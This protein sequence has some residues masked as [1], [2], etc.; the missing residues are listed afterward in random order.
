MEPMS[1]IGTTAIVITAPAN[2]TIVI[3][4]SG[5]PNDKTFSI[6]FNGAGETPLHH[7]P[8]HDRPASR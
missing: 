1:I 4:E 3:A 7:A 2:A 5:T 6:D 8:R